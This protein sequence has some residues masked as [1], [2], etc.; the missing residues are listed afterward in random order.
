MTRRAIGDRDTIHVERP[1]DCSEA[2]LAE[3]ARLVRQG[4]ASADER[5]EDR[6]MNMWSYLAD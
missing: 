5:L 4:F 1:A 6:I 2:Q 3:F